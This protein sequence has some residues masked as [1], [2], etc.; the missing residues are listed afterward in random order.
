MPCS[1]DVRIACYN[2]SIQIQFR[3]FVGAREQIMGTAHFPIPDELEQI[4]ILLEPSNNFSVHTQS[5]S[6]LVLTG[7]Q[8]AFVARSLEEVHAFLCGA[9]LVTFG[10]QRLAD[11]DRPIDSVRASPSSHQQR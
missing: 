2:T 5:D 6:F 10:G 7:D 3:A 9:F 8:L 11:I 1:L 4:L